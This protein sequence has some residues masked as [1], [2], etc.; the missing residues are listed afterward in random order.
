[1]ALRKR[2]CKKFV[3]EEM[4]GFPH[5]FLW[6][7]LEWILIVSLFMDGFLAFISTTFAKI[8]ELEP[9][10]VLCTRVDHM[11]VGK[12]PNTYYNDSICECHKQDISSLAFCHVHRKL[13]YTQN[14]CEGCLLSF[15]TEKESHMDINK[16]LLSSL[17]KGNN[18]FV[19][20]DRK[21]VMK[22]IKTVNDYNSS[23]DGML[24]VSKCSCCGEPL[25][26]KV[27]SK[28][29]A[30]S[31]S[32]ARVS[33]VATSS[34]RALTCFSPKWKH[35]DSRYTELKFICDGE[36]DMIEYEFGLTDAKS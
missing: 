21:M 11:L 27:A 23:N 5:F 8:F 24:D 26:P 16:S 3:V 7:F 6:A 34:P 17:Q 31:F 9:P 20:N 30:R 18:G 36:Q 12:D 1:M 2:S 10:C 13:S 4:G 33:T 14:M 35:D 19:E 22:P 29:Y 28:T 32:N 25:K 15:A